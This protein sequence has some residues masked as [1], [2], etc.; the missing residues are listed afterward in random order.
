MEIPKAS[1]I[2]I[3]TNTISGNCYVGQ[4][5][6]MKRR[7]NTHIRA[8]EK[9]V[10]YNKHLQSAWDKYGRDA[11]VFA[12]LS[13]CPV[14]KLNEE[15]VFYI[16]SLGAFRDGYNM[17]IGGGS[18]FGYKHSES[19]KDKMRENHPNMSGSN[20]PMF[21]H[22][23]REYM[24]DSEI[25]A[26]RAHIAK[27][28]AGENNHFYGKSH[29]YES[30]LK[31]SAARKGKLVGKDNP[32]FG[33]KHSSYSIKKMCEGHAEFYKNNCG[34]NNYNAS[35]VVC[36]NTREVFDC[37]SDACKKYAISSPSI[38]SCCSGQHRSY[39]GNINGVRL[40]WA[41]KQ[42][43]DVMDSG[44]ILQMVID[45]Q[46]GKSGANHPSSKKVI[47]LTTGII[48]ESLGDASTYYGIDKSSICACCRNRA[49][50][51]GIDPVSGKK[52]EWAYYSDY[53]NRETTHE[54]AS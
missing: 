12:V 10:H 32:M 49:K 25:L 38:S 5:Q 35:S 18:N 3:I 40:V 39:G 16:D 9:G 29:S 46:R 50:T 2:Y 17:N 21:G 19:A 24:S 53:A 6:N 54:V 30:R 51:C 4:S 37:I 1:G 11:F 26:W 20:N 28:M 33:K 36:L 41:Y 34:G 13:E 48:F 23:V 43:Y 27:A 22:S 15:E 7:V 45:A 8:L 42:D 14:E 31:I 44:Q 52:L 47:C